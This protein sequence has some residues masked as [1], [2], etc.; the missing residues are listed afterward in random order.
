MRYLQDIYWLRDNRGQESHWMNFFR[1]LEKLKKNCNFRDHTAEEGGNKTMRDVFIS[2]LS[3]HSI[4]QQL[5]ENK[6]LDLQTVY[7]QASAQ[8]LVQQNN[9]LYTTPEAQLATLVNP[10]ASK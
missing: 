7:M 4:W 9:E 1:E 2:G 6:T 10:G 3:S 5:L 8:D